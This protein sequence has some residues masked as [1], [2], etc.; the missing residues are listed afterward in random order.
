MNSMDND[1]IDRQAYEKPNCGSSL[2]HDQHFHSPIGGLTLNCPGAAPPRNQEAAMTAGITRILS[3]ARSRWAPGSPGTA[4]RQA[5]VA[6]IVIGE[7]ERDLA[8]LARQDADT[9][10]VL[11]IWDNDEAV[12]VGAIAGRHSVRGEAPGDRLRD[13]LLSDP[14]FCGFDTSSFYEQG[15]WAVTVTAPDADTAQDLAIE[16]MMRAQ[17]GDDKPC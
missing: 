8:G 15:V 14:G 1:G 11:G 12:P 2:P 9:W 7:I 6:A 10:T 17:H 4:K 5:E 3:E 13:Q 16:E